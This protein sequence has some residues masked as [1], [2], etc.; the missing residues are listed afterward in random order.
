MAQTPPA[1]ESDDL[2]QA[3]RQCDDQLKLWI[4]KLQADASLLLEDPS[5]AAD[6]AAATPDLDLDVMLQLE[7]LLTGL[8]RKLDLNTLPEPETTLDDGPPFARRDS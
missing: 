1:P 6:A 4:S 3:L 8:A 2:L 5:A 7:A